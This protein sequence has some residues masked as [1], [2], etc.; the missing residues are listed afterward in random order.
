MVA[1]LVGNAAP[2]TEVVARSDLTNLW[3]GRV[4]NIDEVT[5]NLFLAGF[6]S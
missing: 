3:R 2:I 6:V 1:D 4:Q 5:T